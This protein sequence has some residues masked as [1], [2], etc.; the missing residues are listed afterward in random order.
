MR[1]TV[2]AAALVVLAACGGSPGPTGQTTPSPSSSSNPPTPAAVTSPAFPSPTPGGPKPPSPA[3]FTCASQIPAGNELALV[4]LRNTSGIVVRD[5][6]NISNPVT[7]CIF[8]G[9]GTYFRF[10]NATHV[11]YLVASDNGTGALYLVDLRARTTSLVRAWTNE[12]SLYWVYAW[13]PDGN[14]LSYLSSNG[15]KVAWHVLSAAGDVILSNLGSVPGR[16]VSPNYDDAMVGFSA[17]GKYVALE[18][19]LTYTGTSAPAGKTAP[20]QVVRLSDRKVVYSRMNGTMA[21]WAG[22]GARL[23]YRTTAGVELWDPTSGPQIVVPQGLAWI[24][25]WPSADGNRIAYEDANGVG[26]HFAAYL[27]LADKQALRIS[28]LPRFGAAFLNSTLV[29][30][31]EESVCKTQCGLGGPPLTGRTYIKDL[32]TGTESLSIITAVFDSWPHIG[33]S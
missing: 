18:Q 13:S 8:K 27:R 32:V 7:R 15:D 19:T 14:T 20:F 31:A 24:H 17:D 9:A 4:T 28:P 22:T 23:Y 3:T 21:T 2:L 12:G 29:W 1:G 10:V 6:S 30:Y 5:I 25:P 11:S 16:G 33:A 26:N